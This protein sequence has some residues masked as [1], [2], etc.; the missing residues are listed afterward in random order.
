MLDALLADEV[1]APVIHAMP[2]PLGRSAPAAEIARAVIFL[3]GPDA[4]YVH[5]QMLF[6]DGGSEA[7]GRCDRSNSARPNGAGESRAVRRP[8]LRTSR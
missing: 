5:G 1:S 2:V 6:V 3:L 8:S 7:L 4:S